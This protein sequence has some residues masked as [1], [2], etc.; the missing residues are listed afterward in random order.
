VSTR[1]G[2]VFQQGG[3][4]ALNLFPCPVGA[5]QAARG[6]ASAVELKIDFQFVVFSAEDFFGLSNITDIGIGTERAK[7]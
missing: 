7:K 2:A 4:N 1:Q 5:H 3:G 6:V